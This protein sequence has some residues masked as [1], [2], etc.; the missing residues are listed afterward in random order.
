MKKVLS[1]ALLIGSAN[2]IA[3]HP[4]R[5][6]L[7]AQFEKP[8]D[9][10]TA[11]Y[12]QQKSW[13]AI[14][15]DSYGEVMPFEGELPEEYK[16]ALTVFGLAEDAVQFHTATRM[17]RFVNGEGNQLVLLRPNFFNLMSRAEQVAE[18]APHLERIRRKDPT[19]I[20]CKDKSA[21]GLN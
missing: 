12:A 4:K 16:N 21:I 20:G 2:I 19:D 3:M 18:I 6:E 1:I 10:P 9:D 5:N 17:K 13:V 7:A 11:M 8:T 14:V 15:H